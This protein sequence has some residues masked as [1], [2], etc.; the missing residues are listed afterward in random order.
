M[1]VAGL[2]RGK[3][4]TRKRLDLEAR[5]GIEPT[6]EAFA[7]PCLTTWLPRLPFQH[8]SDPM[9]PAQAK[10]LQNNVP[11][12]I[13]RSRFRQYRVTLAVTALRRVENLGGK[14]YLRV[15]C[16]FKGYAPRPPPPVLGDNT[17]E[18]KATRLAAIPQNGTDILSI[19]R[20]IRTFR[21]SGGAARC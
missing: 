11:F 16:G 1:P 6:N 12:Q 4:L 19:I 15:R 20:T 5:V 14:L 2:C 3:T 18:E 17:A 7:E 13:C 10:Q 9:G 21:W 8:A